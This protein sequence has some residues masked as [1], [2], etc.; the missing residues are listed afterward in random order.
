MKIA[1]IYLGDVSS[2]VYEWLYFNKPI[3]FYNSHNIDWKNDPYYK[4]WEM[5]YVVNNTDDLI[6]SIDKA[7]NQPDPF[8]KVRTEMRDYTFGKID[9]KASLRTAQK[10]YKFLK[11][12]LK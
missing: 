1:D 11:D 8:L 3:I 5:G 7:L 12:K 2:S 6:S 4:F 10:L 9:G